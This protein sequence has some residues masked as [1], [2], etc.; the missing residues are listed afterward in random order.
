MFAGHKSPEWG[1]ILLFGKLYTNIQK[2]RQIND[3]REKNQ[4]ERY[5]PL[6]QDGLCCVHVEREHLPVSAVTVYTFPFRHNF[7]Q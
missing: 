7:H 3:W 6:C 2:K 1:Y 5:R 4:R